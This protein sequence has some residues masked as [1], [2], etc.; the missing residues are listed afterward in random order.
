M[1]EASAH[2]ATRDVDRA[3][4]EVAALFCPHRLTPES[5]GDLALDLRVRRL[6]EIALVSLDYGAPVRIDPGA[7]D[8]FY[9]VQVPRRGRA[10]VTQDGEELVSDATTAS[11]LSPDRPLVMSWGADTPQSIVYVSRRAVDRQLARLLGHPVTRPVAFR[12]GM[13][14]DDERVRAFRR[15]TDFLH[16]EMRNGNPLL[17]DPRF[18]ATAEELVVGQL[19]AAQP[20]AYSAELLLGSAA[21]GR[22][23]RAACD[24]MSGHLAEP[25]TVADVAEAAGISVRSLQEGF[26]R[27][28]G[29]TPTEWLREQRLLACRS[30]LTDGAP[31][32]HT[33]TGIALDHG[34]LHLGR[35]SVAYRRRFGESPSRT[36]SR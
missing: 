30:A 7:L 5:G 1:G 19:L 20:H 18:A 36:L 12:L 6:G 35:F 23:V 21:P 16:Q 26:R 8:D 13:A 27:E 31:T 9:L 4:E 28:L 11:V 24:L 29:C 34:F 25:L 32:T 3:R 17:A 33:V 14:L 15:A 10:V 2:V 22:V